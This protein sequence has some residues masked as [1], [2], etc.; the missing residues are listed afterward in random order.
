MLRWLRRKPRE[1]ERLYVVEGKYVSLF[2][3]DAD[4]VAHWRLHC[5]EYPS[6][7]DEK[8]RPMTDEEMRKYA[9]D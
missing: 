2:N 4:G 7:A 6:R 1:R 8:L 5:K 3:L 9:F